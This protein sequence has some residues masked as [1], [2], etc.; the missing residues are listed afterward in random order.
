MKTWRLQLARAA[1]AVVLFFNLQCAAAFLWKPEAFAPGF[2]LSGVV[3]SAMLRALGILFI[4]WNVP[5]AIAAWHPFHFRVSLVEANLMQAIG[6]AGETILLWGLPAGFAILKSSMI[7]FIL[8]DGLGLVL[9][10]FA[11]WLTRSPRQD[12][13]QH[14]SVSSG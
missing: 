5:Y 13:I 10:I 3:G 11:L 9:L 7:R 4:M 14:L 12:N 1:I 8:F 6:L 2:E